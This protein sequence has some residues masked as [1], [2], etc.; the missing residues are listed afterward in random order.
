MSTALITWN[1]RAAIVSTVS[2]SI[3]NLAKQPKHS[4]EICGPAFTICVVT[5]VLLLAT[6][7]PA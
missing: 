7:V 3:G 2:R 1:I 6:L 4:Q 5:L